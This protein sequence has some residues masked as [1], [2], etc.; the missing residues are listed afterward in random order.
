MVNNM[1]EVRE[2]PVRTSSLQMVKA[3]L[4]AMVF[5][6]LTS[7]DRSH[8]LLVVFGSVLMILGALSISAALSSSNENLSRNRALEN[9][10]IRY[11]IDY[12]Q[13]L[14]AQSGIEMGERTGRPRWW[15]MAILAGA[16]GIFVWLGW[17]ATVPPLLMNLHWVFIL[18]SLLVIALVCGG[19][20][21]WRQTRF[22]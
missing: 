11:G 2:T 4:S 3:I 15:D 21:L 13:A 22:S 20:A 7:A 14:L 1:I 5:G 8:L 19:W 12:Q 6:E 9:E 16:A 10:C 18:A 17:Q